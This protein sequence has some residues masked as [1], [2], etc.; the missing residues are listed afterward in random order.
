MNWPYQEGAGLPCINTP[1]PT[2]TKFDYT[3]ISISWTNGWIDDSAVPL[4][5]RD[6]CFATG[7]NKRCKFT[8]FF[9]LCLGLN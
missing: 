8:K 4:I 9:V 1:C 3:Q 5:F 6:E 7:K 2:A